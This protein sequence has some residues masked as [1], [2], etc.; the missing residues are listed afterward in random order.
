MNP[1]TIMKKD[2][3]TVKGI[4]ADLEK[5]KGKERKEKLFEELHNELEAH[6]YM[7]E[8]AFYPEIKDPKTT[9]DLTLEAYEE[10]HVVKVLLKELAALGKDH[11]EWDAK[12]K[13]LQENVE[14][15]VKEEENELF[16]KAEKIIGDRAEEVAEKMQ[17]KK[18]EYLDKPIKW[19]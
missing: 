4:F 5:A 14:H 1:F 18:Q 16:P 13:V 6:A 12:L 15:H 9:H 8:K 7:E 2:H 10:H 19:L 3:K 17:E 11:D